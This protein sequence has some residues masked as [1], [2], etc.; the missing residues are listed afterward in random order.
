MTPR[1]ADSFRRIGNTQEHA[2]LAEGVTIIVPDQTDQKA[3]RVQKDDNVAIGPEMQQQANFKPRRMVMNLIVD[4]DRDP[5]SREQPTISPA[6]TLRVKL[7]PEDSTHAKGK[8]KIMMAYWYQGKWII[9]EKEKHGFKIDGDYAA[10][11]LA[12]WG[13]PPI[14][15]GP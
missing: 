10:A 12:V 11:T 5:A 13:D 7:L 9:F 8:D 1:A 4:K 2:F 6:L 15:I 14:A 3:V